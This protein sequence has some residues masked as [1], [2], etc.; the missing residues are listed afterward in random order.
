[1]IASGL[2]LLVL[3]TPP[4]AAQAQ[5]APS[6]Q[7]TQSSQGTSQLGTSPQETKPPPPPP[8][9]QEPAAPP[10]VP[11]VTP[12]GPPAGGQPAGPGKA[13]AA[14]PEASSGAP[15]QAIVAPALAGKKIAALEFKGLKTLSEET[16][17]Y[18][19]GLEI[20]QSLDEERLNKAIRSLWDRGLVDDLK[21]DYTPV[22]AGVKLT[23]TVQER[24]IL[25]SI[26]YE[27][28]KRLSKTDVQDK[29]AT[30]RIKVHE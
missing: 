1:M 25:K 22:A 12:T 17:L 2:P 30:Q 14:A 21:I 24:P 5:A 13:G 9:A 29:I 4:A 18:Y 15:S 8:P 11:L 7:G 27:G 6:S 23:I 10:V 28:L 16:L 3:P 20:G 19:L 26:D